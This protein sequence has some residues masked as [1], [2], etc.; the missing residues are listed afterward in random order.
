ME[1]GDPPVPGQ[2]PMPEDSDEEEDVIG[3]LRDNEIIQRL[4][5]ALTK[6]LSTEHE[7]IALELREKEEQLRRSKQK[8]LDIGVE[9]YG[10]QQ[11]LARMQMQL[12]K[13][14]DNF[15]IIMKIREQA[16]Q[17]LEGVKSELVEQ[18]NGVA[19]QGKKVDQ[20]QADLD[21]LNLT[22]RQ[23]EMYNEQQKHEIA[24]TRRITYKA[25]ETV[26]NL[27]K[28]KKQQDFIIDALN[29][30]MK[31]LHEQLA[32]YE[33]QLISQRQETKSAAETLAQAAGEMEAINFE[34]KQLIQ[35][36]KSSLIGMQR[37]DEALQ[38]AEAALRNQQEQILSLD[39]E[40]TGFKS[41]IKQEQEKNEQLVGML[42]KMQSEAGFLQKQIESVRERR[43]KLNERF[44]MLKKSLEQTDA[45]LA[46]ATQERSQLIKDAA[47][48]DKKI[49]E[50][51]GEVQR[52][53]DDILTQLSE[54]K[55][56]DKG[57]QN[58]IVL[59]QKMRK[60]IHD[61]EM[62]QAQ[63]NNEV[64]RI[65]VDMLNT[66]SHNT[67]LHEN[68]K[69]LE[70][71]LKQRSALIEKYELEIRRR[72]DEIE[73]KQSEVDRLNRRL[74]QL[75]S[76]MEDE[77]LG[78]LEATI[79][80]LSKSIVSKQQECIDMQR[81]WINEQNDLVQLQN[82]SSGQ[83]EAIQQLKS[84]FAVLNQRRMRVEAQLDGH[85]KE[86]RELQSGIRQMHTEMAR[87]NDLLAKHNN[88]QETLV[89]ANFTLE[90]DFARR[91]KELEVDSIKLE[92]QINGLR[93]EK[94]R[95]L[96]EIIEFERQATVWERKIQLERET[97]EAL[98]P[99]VG[100][101]MAQSMRREIHRMKLRFSDLLKTQEHLIKDIEQSIYKRDAI[102]S[103]GRAA[104]KTPGLT[105]GALKKTL[106]QLV[107]KIKEAEAEAAATER[108][109]RSLDSDRSALARQIEE[110]ARSCDT[111]KV[112]EDESVRMIDKYMGDKL[113]NLADITRLQRMA[114]Q[115]QAAK[116][117]KYTSDITPERIS[118][119]ITTQ[120]AR[121]GKL[122][123]IIAILRQ[124]HPNVEPQLSHL[125]ESLWG[126]D[127]Q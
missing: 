23:V 93:D 81:A 60:Q 29:E 74:D 46:K 41:R 4:N 122:K 10:A 104:T 90:N 64:A 13:T 87:L 11:Q 112:R 43:E 78:P 58:V 105:Q 57:T 67:R 30:Q 26:S 61:K 9:L 109:I 103:K 79:H 44:S 121:M 62:Q 22:L 19:V 83:S 63:L 110:L 114:K 47:V 88:Q 101:E 21:K 120:A 31:N 82:E 36:W 35:Q 118:A 111:L 71:E 1:D 16:E 24:V 91:L 42:T 69:E 12:E 15:N 124:Q 17:E 20:Y 39:S 106:E 98:D 34:K 115:V 100:T 3:E 56:I 127:S 51:A 52:T 123:S 73:K 27:E 95:I 68:L 97:S 48:V 92:A 32:L 86:Q 54:Q 37:R 94:Q 53:E 85:E 8:R 126:M 40:I 66:G 89:D 75:L 77:N 55:T 59:I 70:A 113:R 5:E 33:A 107:K 50:V 49:V 117:G 7:R 6:Q 96:N 28:E 80:N 99:E 84:E 108:A 18:R 45:E 125:S 72:N 25:E 102:A 119:E 65:R 14:H 38:A 2:D 76:N 116:E